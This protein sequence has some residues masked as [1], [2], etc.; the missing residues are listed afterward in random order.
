MYSCIYRVMGQYI[1][2]STFL[3]FELSIYLS[4]YLPT[5]LSLYLHTYLYLPTYTYLPNYLPPTPPTPSPHSRKHVLPA[6]WK[7]FQ[8]ARW[9]YSSGVRSPSRSELCRAMSSL[10]P[11]R[12]W[13]SSSSADTDQRPD[14]TGVPTPPLVPHFPSAS[15]ALW[16]IPD[17]QSATR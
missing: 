10:A 7:S 15:P 9:T 5:Y 13:A 4:T 3:R 6:T 2:R 14:L 12:S 17:S 16:L 8:Q 11:S 1:Y